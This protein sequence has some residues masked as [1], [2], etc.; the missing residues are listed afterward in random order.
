MNKWKPKNGD[1]IRCIQDYRHGC[2]GEHLLVKGRVYT[3]ADADG[4][5]ALEGV[6]YTWSVA[7]FEPVEP[8]SEEKSAAP[9]YCCFSCAKF[10]CHII[11]DTYGPQTCD[12]SAGK[13]NSDKCKERKCN[14]SLTDCWQP[15]TGGGERLAE[16]AIKVGD[17][18]HA[19][20]PKPAVST[21][22]Q[23]ARQKRDSDN[24]WCRE[25]GCKKMAM[26]GSDTC[27]EHAEYVPLVVEKPPRICDCGQEIYDGQY[28]CADCNAHNRIITIVSFL[29]DLDIPPF[30]PE[31]KRGVVPLDRPKPPRGFPEHR[32]F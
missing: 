11:K 25:P 27:F 5:L 17:T 1:K 30:E 16:S 18:T 15:K 23:A 2:T 13:Y 20:S 19:P 32:R 29:Q 4:E 22:E 21:E 6:P 14:C 7:R 3:V 24:L 8:V 12:M 26:A 28:F 31:K 9:D 10:P